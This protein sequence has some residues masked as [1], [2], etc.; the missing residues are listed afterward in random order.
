MVHLP[1]YVALQP[2]AVGRTVVVVAPADLDGARRLI[3]AG[4]GRVC[5]VETQAVA[6]PGIECF[7]TWAALQSSVSRVDAVVCLESYA[8]RDAEQRSALLSRALELLAPDGVVAAWAPHGAGESVD[9]WTLEEELAAR[10]EHVFMLA[11]LPWQGVS[12]AP[13]LDDTAAAPRVSLDETLLDH[14]PEASH[15]LAVATRTALDRESRALLTER[16]LLVPAPGGVVREE[17]SAARALVQARRALDEAR[18]VAQSRT[19]RAQVL[20]RDVERL[21]R[22]LA[23]ATA[24]ERELDATRAQLLAQERVA[25]SGRSAQRRV[26][27]LEAELG[28]VQATARQ[29]ETDLAILTRSVQDLETALSRANRAAQERQAE[30]NVREGEV[31]EL[32]ARTQSLEAERGNLSRQ[33]E[34][35]LAER[36]GARQ[37]SQRVE[38]ELELSRRRLNHHEGQLQERSQEAAQLAT[39]VQVSR[40]ELEHQ[41]AMLE[42]A[43]SREEQLS[44]SAAQTVEQGRMLA[45]VAT[46]RDRLREELARRA[47]Q[48]QQ[49]EDRLWSSREELE[50]ERLDNV[51]LGGEAE[52]LRDRAERAHQAESGHATTIQ[53]LNGELHTLELTRA[54]L[55]GTVRA[56]ED[57]I[58]RLRAETEARA[59]DSDEVASLRAELAERG[60]ELGD[61]TA[62]LE[63]TRARESEALGISRKREQQLS[64]VGGEMERMRRAVEENAATSLG[65]QGELE[66]KSLEVEQLAASISDLQSELDTRRQGLETSQGRED[67]LQRALERARGEQESLR[68]RLRE[69]EQ[70][71]EDIASANE[72]SGVELYKLRRELEAAALANE[73]LEEA[74]DLGP[75]SDG[76]ELESPGRDWPID[77]VDALRRLQGQLGAQARRHAEQL[78]AR[79]RDDTQATPRDHR[80]RGLQLEV[81][82][83]AEEQEHMLRQLDSAEQRIWEMTD[84]ADRNAARLAASLAQLEKHKEELDETRDELEVARKL[85]AAAEARALEQERLLSSERAKLARVGAEPGGGLSLDEGI[86]ELFADLDGGEGLGEE[87][88]KMVELATH[89]SGA[90]VRRLPQPAA[91]PLGVPTAVTES[92]SSRRLVSGEGRGSRVL[93]ETI[94]QGADADE[95]LWSKGVV[96]APSADGTTPSVT[97][98]P[99]RP[100][101]PKKA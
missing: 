55:L 27:E 47:Q 77:A 38:A 49:L 65:L 20:E 6:E 29:A 16:C 7:D 90:P 17:P 53:R 46:D 28:S 54:E 2:W 72:T 58:S 66:V 57:E 71:L 23:E 14:P 88:G 15:Y 84:A 3:T 8:R 96:A 32:R 99:R 73:Q 24:Q 39:E 10:F 9:F 89:D 59:G 85:L 5:V 48:I 35:A 92:S 4:A 87:S 41:R 82:V 62:R 45:E 63:Q 98:E 52:R 19:E 74:L 80:V 100:R 50:K 79:S 70:E 51:R 86:D 81:E 68:R 18:D 93:V 22:S 30:L 95:A 64:E 76:A 67:E 37:L 44:V 25:E 91:A 31:G 61:L 26:S 69:R 75:P 42:Q 43:Q 34:V 21:R 13:V 33:L 36:E 97:P 94:A 1:A 11:Q 83:R 12:L 78:A 40:A 60:R 101:T 56:Y